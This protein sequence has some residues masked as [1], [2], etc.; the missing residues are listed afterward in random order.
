MNKIDKNSPTVIYIMPRTD[1]DVNSTITVR[2]DETNEEISVSPT[3]VEEALDFNKVTFNMEGMLKENG[4]YSYTVTADG[5]EVYRGTL[6]CTDDGS[7]TH[8]LWNDDD[9][10]E[11]NNSLADRE[12]KNV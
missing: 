12:Y 10:K 6:Y 11:T 8:S 5:D 1:I 2:D 3:T 7:Y 9:I 4:L